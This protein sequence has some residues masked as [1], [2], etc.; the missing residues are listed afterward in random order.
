MLKSQCQRLSSTHIRRRSLP[1][2]CAVSFES[3]KFLLH[4]KQGSR[5]PKTSNPAFR[6]S[7]QLCRKRDAICTA[8]LIHYFIVPFSALRPWQTFSVLHREAA[9][10]KV[11][12]YRRVPHASLPF[13]Y[14]HAVSSGFSSGVCKGLFSVRDD[15]LLHCLV[16]N[17]AARFFRKPFH[18]LFLEPLLHLPPLGAYLTSRSFIQGRD[19]K[20]RFRFKGR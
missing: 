2:V 13:Q 17:T 11:F 3:I 12:Q 5:Q 9:K 16:V 14:V 4:S 10:K 20:L 18:I 8:T 19:G 7:L 6:F 15:S 1:S